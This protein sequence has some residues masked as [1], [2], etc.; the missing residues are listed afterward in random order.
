MRQAS[1][2]PY[3]TNL[4]NHGGNYVRLWLTD[5]WDDLFIET[6]LGN[7]SVTNTQNIDDLLEALQRHGMKVR[8]VV[9]ASTVI[10]S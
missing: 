3:L 4:S 1:W 10:A 9:F 5:M 7:Y 2:D 8:C 6:H